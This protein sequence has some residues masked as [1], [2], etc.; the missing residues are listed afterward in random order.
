MF[1]WHWQLTKFPKALRHKHEGGHLAHEHI[2][3]RMKL[4]GHSAVSSLALMRNFP[5]PYLLKKG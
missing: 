2:G 3:G 4:M 5:K 1:H